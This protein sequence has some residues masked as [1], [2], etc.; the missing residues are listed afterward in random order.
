M[1][2]IRTSTFRHYQCLVCAEH[3]L[4]EDLYREH[5][6]GLRH[7]VGEVG[8]LREQIERYRQYL[9]DAESKLEELVASLR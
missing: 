1:K 9:A 7:R 3:F 8:Y 2:P 4:T 5:F 6:S